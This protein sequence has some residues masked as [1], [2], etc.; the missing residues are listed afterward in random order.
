MG[1]D[2]RVMVTGRVVVTGR[3]MVTVKPVKL[4]EA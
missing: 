1:R 4:V 3:V 2:I